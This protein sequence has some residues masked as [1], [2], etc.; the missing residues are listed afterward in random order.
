M[1]LAI[2]MRTRFVDI[3]NFAVR[4]LLA[5]QRVRVAPRCSGN[6]L[7]SEPKGESVR[8]LSWTWQYVLAAVLS[9]AAVAAAGAAEYS[10]LG[11]EAP[12][13]ALRAVEG[14]NVRL[15][16][17]RGEVVVL[18]FWGSRCGTCRAQ[19]AALDRSLDTYSSAGLRVFG[20]NVDD[21]QRAALESARSHDVRFPLLLD[22]QKDV[23]RRYVVD[24]LPMT[25][26]IDRNGTIRHVHRDFS[27]KSEALY[28]NQ[29]RALLN[30]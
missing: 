16:E 12:D 9:A 10:L 29:L 25:V 5:L 6:F 15:S 21:D 13:F 2:R 27:A 7:V 23:S 4:G 1:C 19:L 8:R 24:N 30:E 11:R 28:L 18:S 3:V 26:L 14:S 17:H 20:I 22:P